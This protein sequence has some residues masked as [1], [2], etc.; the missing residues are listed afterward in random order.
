MVGSNIGPYR[1]LRKIGEG[2]MGA[3][4]EAFHETIE[5]HV[6]IK[7][8]H[9]AL[10][11][12]PEAANRFVNEARAVNRVDHPGLVQ[13]SDYGQLPDGASYIVMEY[14]KGETL[15]RRI[16]CTGGSLP[17]ADSIRLSLLIA[18]ALAAAH[19]KG[20]IHRDMKPDNIMI[21]TSQHRGG[22]E[23]TKLLD[24]GIAKLLEK[25]DSHFKTLTSA[26]M[27]TPVYM[28]PEQCRGA[29]GVDDKT[30]SYSLGV[31]MYL[32][33]AGRPPFTGQGMG[34]IMGKHM[35][36]E[37]PPLAVLVPT[38]PGAL[39]DLIGRMLRKD[40][41]QRPAMSQIVA[42]LDAMVTQLPSPPLDRLLSTPSA[43]TIRSSPELA[44]IDRPSTLGLSAG[45]WLGLPRRRWAALLA[46]VGIVAVALGLGA[47]T[48]RTKAKEPVSQAKESSATA[49][50]QPARK[51]TVHLRVQSEPPGAT[52]VQ[53]HDGAVLG[54]TPWQ[55]EQR[56]ATGQLHLRLQLAGYQDR[57]LHL[58][59]SK[60]SSRSE[61]LTAIPEQKTSPDVTAAASPSAAKATSAA[62]PYEKRV[63]VRKIED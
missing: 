43:P 26:V 31:M 11:R 3:V 19:A 23:Q 48:L 27:G 2:G 7:V 17:V 49:P 59:L 8:L 12:N 29:A 4:Y 36:E 28:S 42:E 16:R 61:T 60:D 63:R 39:V 25:Q 38:A 30:D 62:P 45:Q 58:E 56:L 33:L 50:E 24:F 14:I 57:E 35:Y 5:R 46:M 10:A 6:A 51:A 21:V 32:M 1:V 37:P 20:I 13:V 40:K 9:P 53:G 52:I 44:S 47:R 15:S 22:G 54:K 18:D 34:E 41:Q 55:S